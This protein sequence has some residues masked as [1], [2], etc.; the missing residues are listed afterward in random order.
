MVTIVFVVISMRM[1][2]R[3][4]WHWISMNYRISVGRCTPVVQAIRVHCRKYNVKEPFNVVYAQAIID[5]RI[6]SIPRVTKITAQLAKTQE[7]CL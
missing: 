3:I 7:S 5:G 1:S 4:R 2:L 6:S